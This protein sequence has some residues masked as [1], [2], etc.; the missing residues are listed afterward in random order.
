MNLILST[1]PV[2]KDLDV[3]KNIESLGL[4]VLLPIVIVM[5]ISGFIG[6]KTFNPKLDRKST[7]LNSIHTS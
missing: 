5:L 3:F 4:K 2:I 6:N 7:R 1:I